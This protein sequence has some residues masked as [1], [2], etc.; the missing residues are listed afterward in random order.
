MIGGAGVRVGTIFVA[1]QRLQDTTLKVQPGLRVVR[2]SAAPERVHLAQHRMNKA[3]DGGEVVLS[4]M[5]ELKAE[6]IRFP[7]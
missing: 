7:R 4:G 1:A 6:H 3:D 5:P 2:L